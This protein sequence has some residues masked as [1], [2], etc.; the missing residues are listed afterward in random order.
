M[1]ASNA[2]ADT[3]GRTERFFTAKDRAEKPKSPLFRRL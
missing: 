1:A 2:V 3:P